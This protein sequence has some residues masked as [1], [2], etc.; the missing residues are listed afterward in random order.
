MWQSNIL[1]TIS[2]VY[3]QDGLIKNEMEKLTYYGLQSR[4]EKLDRIGQYLERKLSADIS[5]H[6][7]GYVD[8]VHLLILGVLLFISIVKNLH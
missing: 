2:F 7:V 4:P 3:L 6:R 5:R 8:S 1:N